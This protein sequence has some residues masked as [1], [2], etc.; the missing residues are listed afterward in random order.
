MVLMSSEGQ[1][2]PAHKAILEERSTVF[3]AMFQ[4]DMAENRNGEVHIE[5]I[6]GPTL[7]H[8]LH[9]IYTSKVD[10][11]TDSNVTKL[12]TAADKYNL[13]S[14]KSTCIR[15]M[16]DNLSVHNVCDSIVLANM[17]GEKHLKES[18]LSFLDKEACSVISSDA[19]K[20][21]VK[22]HSHLAAEVL[23]IVVTSRKL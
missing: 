9:Y 22:E 5:D 20:D 8:I 16:L 11:M 2:F 1:K 21:F 6:D 4:H 17:F 19:W 15:H 23:G 14:L 18:T 7:K 3:D 13:E 12:Y 10:E